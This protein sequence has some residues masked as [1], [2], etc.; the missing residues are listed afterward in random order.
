MGAQNSA[1][2]VMSA[3][4]MLVGPARGQTD[5]LWLEQ[6]GS[7]EHD[8]AKALAA[9]GL[10]GVFAASRTS[11]PPGGQGSWDV[12]LSHTDMT[13]RLTWQYTFGSDLDDE[14]TTMIPDGMGGFFLCGRTEGSLARPNPWGWDAF[15]G[16]Y[17][18]SGK[19]LWL[20]QFGTDHYDLP[21]G[22]APNGL[23][24][25]FVA[26]RT[27][28]DLG[29]PSAGGYDIFLASFD[30]N[31]TQLWIAQFGTDDRDE[32]VALVP[33]GEAGVFLGGHPRGDMGKPNTFR[34]DVFIARC[35]PEGAIVWSTQFGDDEEDDEATGLVADRA[36]GVFL[37]GRTEG[38]LSSPN[39]GGWD[40][41]VARCSGDGHVYWIDQFGTGEADEV[42]ALLPHASGGVYAAGYT[43]GSLWGA[44]A[45]ERDAFLMLY[46]AG[47]VPSRTT[48]FGTEEDD[49]V[50][51]LAPDLLG[52]GFLGGYSTGD[53]W[54]PNAGQGDVLIA[55]FG[56]FCVPD[57]TFDGVLD[58]F[59]FLEFTNEFNSGKNRAD[60]AG[61]GLFDLFDFLCFVNAFNAG[62]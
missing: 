57:F 6:F 52:G 62:C 26:G 55:R 28:G 27:A 33:D 44:G 3:C 30:G 16:R 49:L 50:A 9:D 56:V 12:L 23:G 34:Y 22:L 46:D 25:V 41:F 18:S 61:D 43:N 8:T 13:G 35:D 4:A 39:A 32:S 38:D 24:G 17:D 11:A 51:A 60:C 10:G 37:A 40:G 53:L 54:G 2:L 48:Q 29:G 45:G 36:G 42:L 31:G 59:D 1:V 7:E 5:L 15:I 21:Y 14:P 20:E 47:G 19:Q 58:L